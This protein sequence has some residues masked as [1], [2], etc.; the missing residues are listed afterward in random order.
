MAIISIDYGTRFIGVAVSDADEKLAL[1]HSV[2]E[3]RKAAAGER[4]A[5]LAAAEQVR[6]VLVGVP[7]GLSGNETAQTRQCR[8][9][10]QRLRRALGSDIPVE[11]VDELFTTKEAERRIRSEGGHL[12]QAHAEAARIMLED[13]LKKRMTND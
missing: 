4:I 9:F 1:R 12:S 2:L 6:L 5:Q 11:E 7:R 13:Y 8:A 3:Q 10:V